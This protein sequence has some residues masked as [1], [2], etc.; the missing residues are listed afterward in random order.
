MRISDWS[1]D[2]CSSDLT[3]RD[4]DRV[5]R[6][7]GGD[8]RLNGKAAAVGEPYG[9]TAVEIDR[10][11]AFEAVGAVRGGERPGAAV[12]GETVAVEAGG[13]DPRVLTVPTDER[14]VAGDA[15]ERAVA[16]PTAP[17]IRPAVPGQRV[18]ARAAGRVLGRHPRCRP[19]HRP[20]SRSR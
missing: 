11:D 20:L 12:E 4:E 7:C 2:V 19:A 9:D 18:V 3:R 10:L 17:N 13:D 8:R 16:G 14:V 15:D 5:A 6:R 1:S